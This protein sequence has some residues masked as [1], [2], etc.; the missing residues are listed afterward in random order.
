MSKTRS[1]SG[2]N[3]IPHEAI[4]AILESS[5][6]A[7]LQKLK[8][9]DLELEFFPAESVEIESQPAKLREIN[10][11]IVFSDGPSEQSEP[12]DDTDETRDVATQL[13]REIEQENL[14]ISD[15]YGYEQSLMDGDVYGEAQVYEDSLGPNA[16][17]YEAQPRSAQ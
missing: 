1:K 2:T 8:W 10:P 12:E 16:R 11:Q 6:Q 7:R 15:P 14:M 5:K 3:S 13:Q 9:G 17:R 4:C